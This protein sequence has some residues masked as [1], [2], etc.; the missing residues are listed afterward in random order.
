MITVILS[1]NF[2]KQWR[3]SGRSLLAVCVQAYTCCDSPVAPGLVEWCV[4][5]NECLSDE[6][7]ERVAYFQRVVIPRFGQRQSQLWTMSE[8]GG[9]SFSLYSSSLHPSKPE[10]RSDEELTAS[11]RP[12][13]ASPPSVE[14]VDEEFFLPSGI[15]NY[16]DHTETLRSS[17]EF[18]FNPSLTLADSKKEQ[19]GVWSADTN[20]SFFSPSCLA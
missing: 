12:D 9:M 20:D 8:S 16:W 5:F 13:G 10:Q 2:Y 17:S 4:S 1:H 11:F 18:P 6:T 3:S 14:N 15:V 7:K 19:V